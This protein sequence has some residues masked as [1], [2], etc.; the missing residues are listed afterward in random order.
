MR[1]G[2]GPFDSTHRGTTS[3]T[4][5]E[6]KLDNFRSLLASETSSADKADSPIDVTET[7]NVT[8]MA[9]ATRYYCVVTGIW[10]H[11]GPGSA[12]PSSPS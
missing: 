7:T 2:G 8:S 11:S 5:T 9:R 3:Q 10:A 12:S 4:K 1:T 6:P